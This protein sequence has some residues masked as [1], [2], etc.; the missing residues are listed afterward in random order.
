MCPTKCNH[1]QIVNSFC[2]LVYFPVD[3]KVTWYVA[4]QPP[5][6]VPFT[7]TLGT[8]LWLVSSTNTCW[9][10]GPSAKNKRKG[11]IIEQFARRELLKQPEVLKIWTAIYCRPAKK[12]TLISITCVDFLNISK[13]SQT[14]SQK[15]MLKYQGCLCASS[16]N[17]T[18]W[19][20]GE[21]T[22][23]SSYLSWSLISLFLAVSHSAPHKHSFPGIITAFLSWQ[24]S[25]W[26]EHVLCK[27]MQ[28]HPAALYYET[29][30]IGRM[31]MLSYLP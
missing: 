22:K 17:S 29:M 8:V 6:W 18:E 30:G 11:Y 4:S 23:F 28:F 24:L 14:V 3:F 5:M 20:K 12:T 21:V 1:D 16:Y 31:N 19:S 13:S 25:G 10:L 2:S 15:S 7:N 26:G 27:C 9:M